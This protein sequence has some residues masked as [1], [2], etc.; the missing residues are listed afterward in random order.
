MYMQKNEIFV[1]FVSE[2]R[3]FESKEMV[4]WE[5]YNDYKSI[6]LIIL[7]T[8]KEKKNRQQRLFIIESKTKT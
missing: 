3:G 6:I 1:N 4:D 7:V 8:K 2:M 5:N